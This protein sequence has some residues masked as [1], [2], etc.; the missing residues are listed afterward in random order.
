MASIPDSG[1]LAKVK[2]RLGARCL[3]AEEGRDLPSLVA[4]PE[5]IVEALRDLRDDP[6][7]RFAYLVD[8]TAVD[9]LGFPAKRE[10]RFA[11]VYHLHSFL[12]GGRVRLMAFPAG[13]PPAIG[14]ASPLWGNAA[15]LEREVYDLYGVVF[16]DHPD[17]RRILMPDGYTGH[18]LRKDYPLRGRGER[19]SFPRVELA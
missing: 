8:L 9:Y 5:R 14:S 18:P 11:V 19:S 3:R 17:L 1:L 6:A 12:L 7:L 16:R 13:D 4:D 10:G 15:W 2:E